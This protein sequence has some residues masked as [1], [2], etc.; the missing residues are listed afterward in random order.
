MGTLQ[1][2]EGNVAS[3]GGEWL[4]SYRE[5]ESLPGVEEGTLLTTSDSRFLRTIVRRR[6]WQRDLVPQVPVG[7]EK[8]L[9]RRGA[10]QPQSS[11]GSEGTRDSGKGSVVPAGGVIAVRRGLS[12]L[13]SPVTSPGRPGRGLPLRASEGQASYEGK[14]RAVTRVGWVGRV[15]AITHAATVNLER[16][17]EQGTHWSLP[18]DGGRRRCPG[19]DNC[20]SDSLDPPNWDTLHRTSSGDSVALQS[21][22][23]GIHILYFQSKEKKEEILT[24]MTILGSKYYL[25]MKKKSVRSLSG[26]LY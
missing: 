12:Y 4:R 15:S 19:G 14:G 7:L 13:Q 24:G 23:S 21:Q 2:S 22:Q 11:H 25:F 18:P 16:A 20:L 6:R 10:L 17:A 26:K 9:S 5:W 3:A 8:F 1:D